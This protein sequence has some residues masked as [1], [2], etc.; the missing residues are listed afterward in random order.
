[1][2]L[3]TSDLPLPGSIDSGAGRCGKRCRRSHRIWQLPYQPR[4]FRGWRSGQPGVAGRGWIIAEDECD[5]GNFPPDQID[6]DAAIATSGVSKQPG[7]FCGEVSGL[8]AGYEQFRCDQAH[9]W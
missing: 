1:M 3:A 8:R 4:V 7:P 2:A 5:N 9:G 6:Y